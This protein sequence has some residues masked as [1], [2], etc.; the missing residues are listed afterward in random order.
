MGRA[1][2]LPD[3]LASLE[4]AADDA[5]ELGLG[6]VAEHAAA[7]LET[8]RERA[9]FPGD[10]YVLVLAGGTGVGKS[11]VLNA[12]AG[13]QVSAVRAV[14][15]TT[16]RPVAWVA[17]SRREELAPLLSWLGVERIAG[18]SEEAL[19][20]VAILDLPDFDSIRIENRAVVDAL[21]PR[22]DALAWVVDPEKYDDERLHGYLR[23]LA[24]HAPRMWFILN[25]LDRLSPDALADLRADLAK[26]LGEAGIEAPR[27]LAV[28]AQTGA[29]MDEVRKAI[30][31]EAD[32]KAL[33][34]ARLATD[35]REAVADVARALSV[36]AGTHRRLV[37]PAR[38]EA[39]IREAVAGALAVVDPPGV[40]RQVRTAVMARAR[41]TG[42]SLLSRVVGLI[43]WMTGHERR[44]ADPAAYIRAWRNRGSL[45][46]MLNPV[47][48]ILVE[49]ARGVPADSRAA[50]L[51]A[52]DADDLEPVLVRSLDL[53]TREAAE[54]LEVPG[55]FLW[56]VIGA[57]QLVIGAVFAFAVAWYVTLFL[58]GGV[59]PV[60]TAEVPFLGAVPLPLLMLFG[61]LAVSAIL[62]FLL[63]L[64]AG[65]IGRRRGRRVAEQVRVAVTGAV[66]S[67]GTAGLDRLETVRIRLADDLGRMA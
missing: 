67:A 62:G 20:G 5:R 66:S 59:V 30:A 63:S 49:A 52:I 19:S 26:R 17:E 45:G 53:V 31:R 13:S 46:R 29:G 35:A 43:G 65:S 48:A 34:T 18:H 32:A 42:G 14:R 36:E 12:L 3:R 8:A 58:A 55:S 10:A 40:G 15:P 7:V 24:A 64:H 28:S 23:R 33:V 47:R 16:E 21:L 50:V 56:P 39:A 27:I 4:R 41:R 22:I 9:G 60:T 2:D 38:Q 1:V 44:S 37:E 57:V 11:S 6:V 51:K 25:K 61:S 54:G